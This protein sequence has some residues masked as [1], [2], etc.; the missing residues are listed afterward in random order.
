MNIKRARAFFIDFVIL[1]IM[2]NVINYAFPDNN[3]AKQLKVEQNDILE[4]Y[5]ARNIRFTKYLK[6]YSIVSK[7]LDRE[8]VVPNLAYL[9]FTIIYFVLLPYLWDGR[10]IGSFINGIQIER[11]DKG[12]LQIKQ[13]LIRN[14][15]VIGLGYL[16]FS[17]ISVFILPSKYYFIFKSMV[18]VLQFVLAIFSA[19]MILFTKEKRGIQDL[20][21]NTE[22]AKIIK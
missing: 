11:F 20:I 12:K 16:I 7:E 21:S 1:L 13:L 9:V 10:T 18:G 6:N 17:N 19:Y 2:Y 4:N 5:T 14:I 8:R 3:K 22:M 15:I